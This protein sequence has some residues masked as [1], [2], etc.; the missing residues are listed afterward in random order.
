MKTEALA[1]ARRSRRPSPSVLGATSWRSSSAPALARR[2]S[3]RAARQ[4]PRGASASGAAA[5]RCTAGW[6]AAAGA[7]APFSLL[8]LFL[9]FLKIGAVLFGSG[10]VLLAF[11]RADLVERLGWLTE[12][13]LLDAVAVGQV[14]PGPVFTTAT[15][16][17]YLLGGVAGAAARHRWGSSCR[18]S[19]S[20][21]SAARWCR[22]CAA[23]RWPARS[24]TGSTCLARAD[25]G[26]GVAARPRRPGRRPSTLIAVA[27]A[28][29]LFRHRINSSW[30]VVGG[31]LVGLSIGWFR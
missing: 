18:R 6:R 12:A 7:A 2:A 5:R 28:L 23:R 20:S 31:A 14:T 10:Y 11:L 16:I 29:L 30:L 13:Q 17:G 27:A 26:R 21:R 25:G 9:V 24:S 8:P 22:G 1:V 3:A 4:E 19:S 15:F